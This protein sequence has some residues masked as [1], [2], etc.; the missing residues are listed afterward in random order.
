MEA[1]CWQQITRVTKEYEGEYDRKVCNM[2][3]AKDEEYEIWGWPKTN[4]MQASIQISIA[5]KPSACTVNID[6]KSQ[7]CLNSF[8]YAYYPP[9][10]TFGELV[11]TL[12]KIL[13]RTRKRVMRRAILPGNFIS[14]LFKN[15]FL[16]LQTSFASG[17]FDVS[18]VFMFEPNPSSHLFPLNW[19]QK[20]HF[21]GL[22]RFE[23]ANIWKYIW[24]R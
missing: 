1:W 3:M 4:S 9:N 18:L 7:K 19:N 10:P 23:E 15:T 13:M 22:R 8:R 21:G 20:R 2:R 12:L 16:F 24:I 11:V 17:N 14:K 6:T 5:V